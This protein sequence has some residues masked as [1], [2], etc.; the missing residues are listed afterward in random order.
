[1]QMT[2]YEMTN[3]LTVN[4]NLGLTVIETQ[5]L[6]RNPA[7][8]YLAALG[9][10][11]S[12][13]VQRQALNVI[14]ELMGTPELWIEREDKRRGGIRQE[15]YRC[16]ALDWA[17]LRVEHTEMIRARLAER[18]TVATA[19]RAVSAMRAVL[20]KARRLGLIPAEDYANAIDLDPIDGTTLPAG[21][22]LPAGEI[23]ALMAACENDLTPGGARDCALISLAYSCGLRRDELATLDLADYDPLTDA[24]VVRHGKG[25]KARTTYLI[26]GAALAMADWLAIRGSEPGAL[27][28]PIKKGG[29]LVHGKMTP[30]AIYNLM[31]KRGKDAGIEGF[32][33]HDLRR[34]FISDLLDKGAD[35]S[36]VAKL[37]GHASVTTT[38]RYDRRPEAAKR[39][40]AEL[41]YVPYRGR[42]AE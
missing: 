38:A 27:F 6:D 20:K 9:N 28:W 10:D 29:A 39:Q 16:L 5:P 8:V 26:N 42:R 35:I 15:D 25:N 40:A 14:A 12:R 37:A 36:T 21:R 2:V 23:S 31:G 22:G 32:S 3:E 11:K 34:S 4:N 18:F 19:K 33:P 7:A 41:L 1:M 13:R 24:L 30:Q 17:A